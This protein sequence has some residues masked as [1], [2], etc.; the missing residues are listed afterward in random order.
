VS[1][2]LYKTHNNANEFKKK[3]HHKPK[4]TLKT[5]HL[6]NIQRLLSVF[7]QQHDTIKIL[8][9]IIIALIF[10]QGFIYSQTKLKEYPDTKIFFPPITLINQVTFT[11]SAFNNPIAGCA[12]LLENDC[13]MFAVTC[14]HALWVAKSDKMKFVHFEGTLKEWEMRRKDDSTN[15]V[16]T[17]KLLNENQTELIGENNVHSDYLVFTIKEN[18]SDVKPVKLRTGEL[19]KDEPLYLVGWSFADKSGPQRVYRAKFHKSIKDH[20]LIEM[21]ENKNLAGMSGS[22]VLDADGQL[23]GIISNYTYDDE[24]KKWYGSPCGTDYLKA[25]LKSYKK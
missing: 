8:I 24:T 1:I 7:F 25:V 17:D 16:I 10:L 13:D 19:I 18:H 5:A 6:F 14:K 4:Q 2:R 21:P 22:P 15:Y 20:I 23:V 3:F 12:F 9:F 11:D